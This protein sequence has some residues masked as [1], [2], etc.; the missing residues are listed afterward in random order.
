MSAVLVPSPSPWLC[1]MWCRCGKAEEVLETMARD[2]DF[3]LANMSPP[4]NAVGA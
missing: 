4:F 1:L 3:D 2:I